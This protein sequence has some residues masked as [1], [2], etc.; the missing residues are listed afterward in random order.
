[1]EEQRHSRY[2]GQLVVGFALMVMGI[3]FLMDNADLINIGPVW[4]FWPLILVAGG[5]AKFLGAQRSKEMIQGAWI[6][7]A[8]AWIYISINHVLGLH[9]GTTWPLLV[10]AWGITILLKGMLKPAGNG[11]QKEGYC[12]Q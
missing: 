3:L 8:G 7:F 1:M 5:A 11:A 9:F 6:A 4:R 2:S 10:I 12:G